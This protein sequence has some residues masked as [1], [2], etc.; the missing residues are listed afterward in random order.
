[1][2]LNTINNSSNAMTYVT[3][4]SCTSCA[5]RLLWCLPDRPPSSPRG[6]RGPRGPAWASG[7]LVGAATAVLPLHCDWPGHADLLRGQLWRRLLLWQPSS[8][9]RGG[10]SSSQ[11][12]PHPPRCWAVASP[13]LS[14]VR[15]GS[16]LCS[17]KD[18]MCFFRDTETQPCYFCAQCCVR[19]QHDFIFFRQDLR[20]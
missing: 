4:P 11:S 2:V 14:Y 16:P 20:Q 10:E 8:G 1:M 18:A 6:P 5:H 17:P 15:V 19:K 3:P 9:E 7:W 12:T 13:W